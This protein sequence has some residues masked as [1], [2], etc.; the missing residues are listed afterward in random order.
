MD[1]WQILWGINTLLLSALAF[2]Y[3]MIRDDMKSLKNDIEKRTLIV[4]CD[5]LHNELEK[6]CERTHAAWD[7]NCDKIHSD[8]LSACEKN[9]DDLSRAA[10]VHGNFGSSGEAIHR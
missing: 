9:H 10:H 3:K 6:T 8:I 1:M 4:T 5:K 7:K 2:F